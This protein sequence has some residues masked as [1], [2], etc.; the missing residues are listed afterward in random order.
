MN[1]PKLT[2]KEL[3]RRYRQGKRQFEG[4]DLSA[5]LAAACKELLPMVMG[6][7]GMG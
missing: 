3:R 6:I 2:A 7:F 1:P 4:V 5:M